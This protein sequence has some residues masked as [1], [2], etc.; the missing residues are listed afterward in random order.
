MDETSSHSLL[1]NPPEAGDSSVHGGN[2]HGGNVHGGNVQNRAGFLYAHHAQQQQQHFASAGGQ[3]EHSRVV[4][5]SN[6]AAAALGIAQVSRQP[7]FA[8][9]TTTGHG[10]S[11]EHVLLL[12]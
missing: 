5:G 6:A 10:A 9:Q 4:R 2:V 7:Y 8:Q 12:L 3:H 11:V 1:A